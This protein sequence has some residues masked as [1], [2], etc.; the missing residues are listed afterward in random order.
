MFLDEIG[1]MSPALQVKVLR[2]LQE[3]TF[4]AV[5][6]TEERRVDV[7]ILAATNRDLGAMVAAGTFREDLYYRINVIQIVV[8]ALRERPEDVPLLV[9]HFLQQQRRLGRPAPRLSEAAMARLVR[10]PWPGNVRELENEIERLAVLGSE[11]DVLPEELISPRMRQRPSMPPPPP[12]VTLPEAVDALERQMI[13]DALARHGGNK[14]RAA[15]E[16]GVSRRNLIRL[17]QKFGF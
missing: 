17:A 7:R 8:P 9:E 14:S 11:H 16:L 4:T 13:A 10:Y 1:D 12:G 5:G 15:T 6:D 2:V 3:G